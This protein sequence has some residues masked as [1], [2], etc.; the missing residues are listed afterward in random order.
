MHDP[1][2]HYGRKSKTL[3]KCRIKK[4]DLFNAV[5]IF[6]NKIEERRPF[7]WCRHRRRPRWEKG[8]ETG[9]VELKSTSIKSIVDLLKIEVFRF[10][11][12]FIRSI[13]W[14][15]L[16]LC[17]TL[18]IGM[19]LRYKYSTRKFGRRVFASILEHR[20]EQKILFIFQN[21][22]SGYPKCFFQSSVIQSLIMFLS[23]VFQA[24]VIRS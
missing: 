9:D 4:K 6:R 7:Q 10:H 20:K 24:S 23:S 12:H 21:C 16:L 22:V 17:H 8:R 3:H 1:L 5:Q 2:M 13:Y 15:W 19:D 11:E 14:L 18:I